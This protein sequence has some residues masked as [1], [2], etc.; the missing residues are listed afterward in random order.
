MAERIDW[1]RGTPTDVILDYIKWRDAVVSADNGGG[2]D[3]LI[4][5]LRSDASLGADARD[6]IADLLS[7]YR[8]A[9]KKGGQARPLGKISIQEAEMR[10]LEALVRYHRSKGMKRDEAI[11][12]ALRDAKR[13][14]LALNGD[15]HYRTDEE[16][17][18][19]ISEEEEE[20]LRNRVQRNRRR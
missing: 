12:P 5:L 1:V 19:M 10:N 20:R 9:N 7:K 2:L 8:L 18:A 6:L 14:M 13:D 17:D 15:D 11:R 16:I 3:S 4:S